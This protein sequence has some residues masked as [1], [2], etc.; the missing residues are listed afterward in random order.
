MNGLLRWLAMNFTM[1]TIIW[2]TL[3]ISIFIRDNQRECIPSRDINAMIYRE[4][5]MGYRDRSNNLTIFAEHETTRPYPTTP[6]EVST[7]VGLAI[8]IYGK[9]KDDKT[10]EP[11]PNRRIEFFQACL[12]DTKNYIAPVNR[13]IYNVYGRNDIVDCGGSVFT[14]EY[15][16]Y[17]FDT[18]IPITYLDHPPHIHYIVKSNDTYTNCKPYDKNERELMGVIVLSDLQIRTNKKWFLWFCYI[19]MGVECQF[20]SYHTWFDINNEYGPEF[21]IR[22]TATDWIKSNAFYNNVTKRW[23]AE[24]DIVGEKKAG[25]S[26]FFATVFSKEFPFIKIIYDSEY[27]FGISRDM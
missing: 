14:N 25:P 17:K 6:F 23:M 8:T 13:R 21:V 15:G 16:E 4:N 1:I 9:L 27:Q 5:G 18:R 24:F 10:C 12:N 20:P 7:N 19:F 11:I 26:K 3:R 22:N 2:I